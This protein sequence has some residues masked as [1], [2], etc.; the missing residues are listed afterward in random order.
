M[1]T[2]LHVESHVK[3]LAR[4]C[5]R[6]EA[7]FSCPKCKCEVVI[8]KGSIRVHHFAHKPPVSCSLGVGE[9]EQHLAAKLGVYD[10]LSVENNV[11]DLELEKDFG[12]SVA[13]VYARISGTPVAVEIQRSALSV[14]DIMSRTRNYHRLG[15]AVLWI[16]LA[17]P[18][19]VSN[20]Y[21]PA[22]WEKWCHAAYFGRV[23][24]WASGQD[25]RVVH[26]STY[27]IH[28]EER[29]WFESGSE[30]SAGGYSK[31]SKRWRRPLEGRRMR[32]SSNFH[33]VARE[34]WSG[35]TVVVPECTLYVDSQT[36]WWD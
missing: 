14:N 2:A 11:S 6:D 24:Y 34:A 9:T 19:L 28:V 16:G 8:R 10:A 22:A 17:K 21:S 32:L 20:K 33:R 4:R 29:S 5:E 3:V 7:P 30:H 1:L 26:F 25:L 13:D 35:G 23:Y 36:K 15:I 27:K 18:E 12:V 31:G